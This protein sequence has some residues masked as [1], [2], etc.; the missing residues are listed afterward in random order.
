MVKEQEVKAKHKVI[1]IS[2]YYEA[3]RPKVN[4][5][6]NLR[7]VALAML[8]DENSANIVSQVHDIKSGDIKFVVKI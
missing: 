3:A 7:D 6:N 4:A 1:C 8:F 5:S 2:E